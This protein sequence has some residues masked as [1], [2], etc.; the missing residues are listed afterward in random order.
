M[1]TNFFD[2]LSSDIIRYIF[3][4]TPFFRLYKWGLLDRRLR[5]LLMDDT[6]QTAYAKKLLDQKDF[7]LPYILIGYRDDYYVSWVRVFVQ[8]GLLDPGANNSLA[9]RLAAQ[10]NSVA[11]VTLF[12]EDER[13]DKEANWGEAFRVALN[14]QHYEIVDLLQN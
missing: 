9:L 5:I 6:F 14:K 10:A 11:L 1:G 13:V 3:A 4:Q 8:V 2:R 7:M 12:L